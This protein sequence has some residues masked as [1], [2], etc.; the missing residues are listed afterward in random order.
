MSFKDRDQRRGKGRGE[1]A[2]VTLVLQYVLKRHIKKRGGRNSNW[3]RIKKK[4]L[5]AEL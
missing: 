5:P 3:V 4:L 2:A 1:T